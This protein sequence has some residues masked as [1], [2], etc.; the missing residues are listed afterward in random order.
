M[1]R[2]KLDFYGNVFSA[3]FCLAY[4]YVSQEQAQC[5]LCPHVFDGAA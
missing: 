2:G 3:K 5:S 1:E 4:F